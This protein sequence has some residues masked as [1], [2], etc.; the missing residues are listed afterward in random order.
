M[1]RPRPAA[2][3]VSLSFPPKWGSLPSLT[4]LEAPGRSRPLPSPASSGFSSALPTGPT[5]EGNKGSDY[6]IFYFFSSSLSALRA[7]GARLR[8]MPMVQTG[9][10]WQIVPAVFLRNHLDKEI[11]SSTVFAAGGPQNMLRPMHVQCFADNAPPDMWKV[12]RC[13]WEYAP[14]NEKPHQFHFIVMLVLVI[15]PV[16]PTGCRRKFKPFD[17]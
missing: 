10:R 6:R 2:N 16:L 12:N 9:R 5:P 7:K 11:G 3:L 1:P 8:G 17:V 14:R 4:A 15:L 13:M